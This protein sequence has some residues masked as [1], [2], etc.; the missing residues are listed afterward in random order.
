MP[1]ARITYYREQM[2]EQNQAR[3]PKLGQ[4]EEGKEVMI[5]YTCIL[6]RMFTY[7]YQQF[8]TLGANIVIYI[9]IYIV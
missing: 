3:A 7:M 8:L 4:L 1:K 6:L 2:Y 5:L 9:Y